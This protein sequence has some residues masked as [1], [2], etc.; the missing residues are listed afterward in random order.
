MCWEYASR[1]G[2]A[3]GLVGSRVGYRKEGVERLR[4]VKEAVLYTDF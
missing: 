3:D 2:S 4:A 1:L